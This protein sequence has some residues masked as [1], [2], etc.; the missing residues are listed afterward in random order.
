M[1]LIGI[2]PFRAFSSDSARNTSLAKQSSLV[3][4]VQP[5]KIGIPLA[6]RSCR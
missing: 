5:P 2:Y 3:I 4:R 6:V 1:R